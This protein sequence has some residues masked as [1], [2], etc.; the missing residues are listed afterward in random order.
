[1]LYQ[2]EFLNYI[3]HEKRFSKHTITAYQNDL[4]QFFNY[5]KEVYSL[6]NISEVYHLLIRSRVVSV[7]EQGV[8]ARS[9]NRKITTLKTY[10]KFLLKE[11]LVTDSPMQKI[12][13]PKVS[14]RLPVFVEEQKMT[15]MFDNIEWGKSMED[16]QNKLI[17]EL[18]YST[19]MRLSELIGLT[20]KSIDQSNSTIKV[21]GKRNKERIIPITEEL[22][23]KIQEHIVTKKKSGVV[24]SENHLF[25][26]DKGKKMYEK[27]VY[28]M[29][30]KYLSMVSTIEKK[31]P[32][33]LRHTFATHMLNNGADI[34]AIKELLGHASLA[35]T[36]V[37]THNTIEKLKNIYKQAH[38]KA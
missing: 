6:E 23:K 2:Q 34:N 5:L 17:L 16:Q 19:G 11:N 21:L 20:E 31:S 30:N 33:V 14:K 36:Q 3:S 32:H 10:Y 4:Q 12:Q 35:A 25:V 28:R 38:P 27:L 8:T 9:V 37:Y 26:T 24:S 1:M 15:N 18:F 7:M 29:V 13:T 22:R